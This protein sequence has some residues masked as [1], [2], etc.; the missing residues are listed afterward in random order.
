[1]SF[2][3]FRPADI[4]SLGCTVIEMCTGFPP[5]AQFR[6]PVQA[7]FHIAAGTVQPVIP[8]TLSPEGQDFIS[9]CL[10]RA[11]KDRPTASMLLNH[12][13]VAHVFREEFCE[14]LPLLVPSSQFFMSSQR[15]G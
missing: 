15:R 9:V 5:F 13:F 4:W 3:F 6:K 14:S 12:P 2:L 10:K 7:M 1:M 8:D 11:P